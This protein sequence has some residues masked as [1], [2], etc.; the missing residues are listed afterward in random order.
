MPAPVFDA[1]G[2]YVLATLRTLMPKLDQAARGEVTDLYDFTHTLDMQ[3]LRDMPGPRSGWDGS[4]KGGASP[5]QIALNDLVVQPLT[6][7]DRARDRAHVLADLTSARDGAKLL[8]SQLVAM[9]VP[10]S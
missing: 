2:G 1:N 10:G 8:I 3:L 4:L 9:G 6:H 7:A 5:I